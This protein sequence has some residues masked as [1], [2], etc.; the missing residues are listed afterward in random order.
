MGWNEIRAAA[1]K[2]VHSQFALPAF[3]S[4]ADASTIEMPVSV[5]LH[6][7]LKKFGDLDREGYARVLE[8]VNQIVFDKDEVM[9]ERNATVTFR[10]DDEEDLVY[11]LDV[12]LPS[13]DG[14]RYV[15]TEVSRVLP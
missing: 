11:N 14:G 7:D 5:R 9:P 12:I 2:I 1:R 13:P 8:T 4:T 3:Y 10:F 6:N 15:R